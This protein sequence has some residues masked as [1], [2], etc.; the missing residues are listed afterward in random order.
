MPDFTN[1]APAGISVS[2]ATMT[3]T[4]PTGITITGATMTNTA[5]V[6][7]NI[8]TSLGNAMFGADGFS[9]NAVFT[10]D[11]S[12][13]VCSFTPGFPGELIAANPSHSGMYAKING[14][15][16][17]PKAD[18]PSLGVIAAGTPIQIRIP[19]TLYNLLPVASS[20][21]FMQAP[22]TTVVAGATMSNT[23]PSRIAVVSSQYARAFGNGGTWP[24][25]AWA[26]G[27]P[28]TNLEHFFYAPFPCVL[29]ALGPVPPP[30]LEADIGDDE[31]VPFSQWEAYGVITKGYAVVLRIVGTN[32]QLADSI[33]DYLNAY[34][35]PQA[36]TV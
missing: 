13:S 26:Q 4:A 36:N 34:Q 22:Q 7:I 23:E 28:T 6:V 31:H 24:S 3:D 1:T 35:A 8:P 32:D 2:G 10:L 30:T 20:A 11:A 9:I 21:N 16:N 12:E 18:W 14:G 17:I 27:T 25:A 5:P 33:S 19:S 29:R 15:A